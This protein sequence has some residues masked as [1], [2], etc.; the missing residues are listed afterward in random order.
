M[1]A[2]LQVASNHSLGPEHVLC[3]KFGRATSSSSLLEEKRSRAARYAMDST[4]M[5]FAPDTADS[6]PLYLQNFILYI[7]MR[8]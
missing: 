8:D 1:A 4:P 2:W 3:S 7:G 6:G 5:Y